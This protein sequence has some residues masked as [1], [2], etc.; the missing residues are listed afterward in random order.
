[1]TSARGRPGAGR[2]AFALS[3]EL[4]REGS[5]ARVEGYVSIFN[6]GT[7]ARAPRVPLSELFDGPTRRG[8]LV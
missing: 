5:A 6:L 4:T 8:R 2:S 7:I 1:M 3:T